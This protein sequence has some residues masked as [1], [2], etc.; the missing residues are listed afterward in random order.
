[1]AQFTGRRSVPTATT[2]TIPTPV[3]LTGTMVQRGLAEGYSLAQAPGSVTA[4]GIGATATEGMAITVTA[5]ARVMGTAAATITGTPEGATDIAEDTSI[6]EDTATA[7]EA[8]MEAVDSAVAGMAEAD[9]MAVA[10]TDDADF[11]IHQCSTSGCRLSFRQPYSFSLSGRRRNP[12]PPIGLP[13][14]SLGQLC[15]FVDLL[16]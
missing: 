2:A 7:E 12:Q 3:H 11:P 9:F 8:S 15:G 10:V 14:P 1:M 5:T 13:Q 6:V 16:K 4:M